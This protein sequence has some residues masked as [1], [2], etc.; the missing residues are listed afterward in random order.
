[1]KKTLWR[2][3]WLGIGLLCGYILGQK[4]ARFW[5]QK[6]VQIELRMESPITPFPVIWMGKKPAFILDDDYTMLIA[7]GNTGWTLHDFYIDAN[8]NNIGGMKCSGGST[9][10][11]TDFSS[12]PTH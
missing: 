7:K 4:E 11:T 8:K 2:L 5:L 1:M 6:P 10:A 12:A 9:G 3:W